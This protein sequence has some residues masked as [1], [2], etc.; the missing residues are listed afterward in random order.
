MFPE[1]YKDVKNMKS[2]S[3]EVKNIKKQIKDIKKNLY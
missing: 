2:G 3:Q 1:I